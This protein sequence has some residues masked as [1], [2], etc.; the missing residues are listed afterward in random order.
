MKQS[1]ISPQQARY[2]NLFHG[3][4]QTIFPLWL[5]RQAGR[6]LPE[7]RTLRAKHN[8]F[9]DLCRN[10]FLASTITLQPLCRF[11]LD[12]AII[13]ADILLPLTCFSGIEL[14][15]SDNK[16]PEIKLNESWSEIVK[17]NYT[18][19][20]LGLSY[21]GEAIQRVSSSLDEKHALIGFCGG[22]WTVGVYAWQGSSINN[23][24]ESIKFIQNN[25]SEAQEF[26]YILQQCSLDYLSMQVI[27][28]AT[29]IMIFESWSSVCPAELWF[30]LVYEYSKNLMKEFKQL[31]P[32]IPLIY[33]SRGNI[34]KVLNA[35]EQ[36][37]DI[38]ACDATVHLNDIQEKTI[39]LLQGNIDPYILFKSVDFIEEYVQNYFS[40]LSK[41]VIVNLGHGINPLT[42][43]EHVHALINAVRYQE[44]IFNRKE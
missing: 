41:P 34:E 10:P 35:Q 27:A 7:Y 23:F 32:D 20:S 36:P 15:F 25:L 33:Y 6:Y 16:G 1:I 22:P 4:D 39:K 43:V 42:P 19:P 13:F 29:Q 17:K 18:S 14:S 21:V 28:G 37:F 2:K 5:M 24:E 8:S 11:E 12:A 26:L 40:K 9:L 38:L 44:S 3:S 30:S 31:Y